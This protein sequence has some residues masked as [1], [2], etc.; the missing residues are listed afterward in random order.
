MTPIICSFA[1]GPDEQAKQNPFLT[2]VNISFG[3]VLY[4]ANIFCT[5]GSTSHY[6]SSSCIMPALA[7]LIND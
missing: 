5:C 3:V 4:Y 6:W 7:L 2:A 1:K